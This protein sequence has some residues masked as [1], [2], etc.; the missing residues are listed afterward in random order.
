MKKL[1]DKLNK[2]D[3]LIPLIVG[4]LL[5]WWAYKERE[6]F[7]VLIVPIISI[8]FAKSRWR[9]ACGTESCDREYKIKTA[10]TIATIHKISKTLILPPLIV[11]IGVVLFGIVLNAL[12]QQYLRSF[13][14]FGVELFFVTMFIFE[15][16]DRKNIKQTFVL[17]GVLLL[18]AMVLFTLFVNN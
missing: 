10:E 18:Y 16:R 2:I 9:A 11:M 12:N 13:V 7:A 17:L 6:Y 15:V 4:V 14:L 5:V 3:F 8:I 1:K